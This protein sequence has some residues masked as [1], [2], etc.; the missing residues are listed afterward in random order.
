MKRDRAFVFLGILVFIV[1]CSDG[2]DPVSPRAPTPTPRVIPT[3]TPIPPLCANI[4]GSWNATF[5]NSCRGADAGL[6]SVTQTGCSFVATMSGSRY[7]QAFPGTIQGNRVTINSELAFPCDGRL[8]GIG[9]I[10]GGRSLTVPYNG[11]VTLDR[12]GCPCAVGPI[13]GTFTLTR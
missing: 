10:V 1:G 5:S 2:D 9:D 13:N 12:G 4:A 7:S 11:S 6:A 3:P 8:T